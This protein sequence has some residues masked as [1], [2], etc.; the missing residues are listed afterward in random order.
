MSQEE[1]SQSWCFVTWA[2]YNS[3]VSESMVEFNPPEFTKDVEP[4]V[5]GYQSQLV[6]AR[7]VV[8]AIEKHD[9]SVHTFNVLPDHVH[10][11]VKVSSDEELA[12]KIGSIKG[13]IANQIRKKSNTTSKIWASKFHRQWIKDNGDLEKIVRYIKLNHIKHSATWGRDYLCGFGPELTEIVKN[14]NVKLI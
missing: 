9:L 3:R 10:M 6:V 14:L 5:F 12:E 13:Y 2:T 11:L 4:I 8:E 1:V 7:L